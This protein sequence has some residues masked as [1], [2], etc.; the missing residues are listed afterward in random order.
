MQ[1]SYL[2]STF[3][4]LPVSSQKAPIKFGEVGE[5]TS[6]TTRLIRIKILKKEGLNWADRVFPT[7]Y[8]S[9]IK[10]ITFNLENGVILE[11]KL[12]NTSIFTEKIDE[13]HYQT[14]VFMPNVRV[15]CSD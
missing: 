10:G 6:Y 12:K 3:I 9:D 15:G 5:G 11:D 4:Y 8:K 7:P 14:R 2:I 1:F 13:N